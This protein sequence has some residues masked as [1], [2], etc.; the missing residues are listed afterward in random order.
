MLHDMDQT[1]IRDDGPEG[2]SDC[3]RLDAG[4]DREKLLDEIK[5]LL[6]EYSK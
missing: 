4:S 2:R 3:L 6:V 5:E 1:R